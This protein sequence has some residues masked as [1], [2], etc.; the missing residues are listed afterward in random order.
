[1]IKIRLFLKYHFVV[2]AA[3][4]Y[5]L[6]KMNII[7]ESVVVESFRRK[8]AKKIS[9]KYDR[10]LR[11]NLKNKHCD[12]TYSKTIWTCWFQGEK[13]APMIVKQC[14]ASIR[15]Q[16]GN[17]WRV[18]VITSEN[19][20][21]YASIPKHIIEKWKQGLI[22]DTHFSDI[23]RCALLVEHGGIWIDATCFLSSRIPDY[24]FNGEMFCFKH[25]Y[26]NEDTIGLGSWFIFSKKNNPLL[27][28]VLELEADYWLK[29]KHLDDYFLFHIFFYISKKNYP[30]IWNGMQSMSDVY[31]H[32]LV[33]AVLAQDY[34]AEKY[35]NIFHNSFIH[36]VSYKYGKNNT[37]KICKC[38]ADSEKYYEK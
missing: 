27:R 7:D 15:K 9:K 25:K 3:L 24:V 30:N 31:P 20:E 33:R 4:F 18:V 17:G 14:L 23:L 2:P 37:K 22:T 32:E 10:V 26:R 38:L 35:G 21:E 12:K 1:M 28:K 11:A 13:E 5:I 8:K 29:E 19:I 34:D 16:A 6:F 36:K